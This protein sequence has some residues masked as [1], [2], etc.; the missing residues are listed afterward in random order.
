MNIIYLFS[1]SFI[2]IFQFSVTRCFIYWSNLFMYFIVFDT[3]VND[4]SFLFQITHCFCINMQLICML[5]SYPETWLNSFDCIL[6]ARVDSLEF[7]LHIKSCHLQTDSFTYCFLIW[8]IF[9]YFSVNASCLR[10]PSAMLNKSE[11]VSTFVLFLILEKKI[12][13]L[14]C[15][16]WC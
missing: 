10:L 11:S 14:Y 3:I 9:V 13:N 16:I 5:I 8:M 15:Y 1:A 12:F 6:R 4:C 7:F 2:S